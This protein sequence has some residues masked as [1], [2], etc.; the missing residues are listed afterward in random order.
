MLGLRQQAG[1]GP[2]LPPVSEQHAPASWAAPSQVTV[3]TGPLLLERGAVASQLV[4]DHSPAGAGP[5]GVRD[6]GCE[7]HC[8]RRG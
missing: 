3:V 5:G 6:S 2:S 1:R 8:S 4:A 7:C